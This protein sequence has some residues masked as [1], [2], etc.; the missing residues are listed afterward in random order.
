MR[1]AEAKT[2]AVANP[3]PQRGGP[4]WIFLKLTTD[5]GIAGYGEAYASPSARARCAA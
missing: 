1:I 3:D 4:C 2:W 5:D